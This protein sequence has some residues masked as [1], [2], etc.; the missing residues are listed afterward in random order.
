LRV[1]LWNQYKKYK[2]SPIQIKFLIFLKNNPISRKTV[3]N[4][5]NEFNLTKATVSDAVKTLEKKGLIIRKNSKIDK[6]IFILN[7]TGKGRKVAK[8][9]LGFTD[10]I[11]AVLGTLK[12]EKRNALYSSL[13][14]M[15]HQFHD[16][17]TIKIARICQTCGHF[18]ITQKG[19]N[20]GYCKRKKSALKPHEIQV[21]CADH[22]A[23]KP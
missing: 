15:I 10:E 19:H 20:E 23:K 3:S 21:N 8:K 14:E 2:L 22:H 12:V 1:N 7:P 17:G 13:L 11:S 18:T 5:A 9:L 16:R 6:R 4:L